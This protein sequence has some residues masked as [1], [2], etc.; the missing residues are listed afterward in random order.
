MS[1]LRGHAEFPEGGAVVP[2]CP[3]CGEGP[4]IDEG[5]GFPGAPLQ[6]GPLPIAPVPAGTDPSTL[7]PPG[8]VTPAPMPRISPVPEASPTPA[9][10]GTGASRR[11]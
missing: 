8:G 4:V 6:T 1:R 5:G 10:P 11:K 3:A 2:G 7:V 9:P